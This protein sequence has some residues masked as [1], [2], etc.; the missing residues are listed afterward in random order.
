MESVPDVL[1]APGSTAP[2]P[3]RCWWQVLRQSWLAWWP[4]ALASLL[5]LIVAGIVIAQAKAKEGGRFVYRIDDCYFHMAVAK[6]LLRH[7]I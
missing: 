5:L 4:V 6:N 1:P 2:A 7:G 3:G